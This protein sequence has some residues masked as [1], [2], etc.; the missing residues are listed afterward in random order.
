[1][2]K[3][4][5][6]AGQTK[7]RPLD[8]LAREKSPVDTSWSNTSHVS[9]MVLDTPDKSVKYYQVTSVNTTWSRITQPKSAQIP[10]PESGEI[11]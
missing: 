9:E 1:M 2:Y 3:L 6:P 4:Q 11:W 8:Y 10:D 7:W 5:V